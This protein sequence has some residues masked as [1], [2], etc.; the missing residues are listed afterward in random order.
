MHLM[1]N[2]EM[3][4]SGTNQDVRFETTSTS[5]V[6]QLRKG[7]VMWVRLRQGT[8][9]GHTPSHYSTFSGYAVSL[10]EAVDSS[11]ISWPRADAVSYSLRKPR[12]KYLTDPGSDGTESSIQ[13]G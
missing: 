6:L 2:K 3:I 12:S 8:V 11:A 13:K 9:Y 4:S 7:D 5:A 1:R 10:D